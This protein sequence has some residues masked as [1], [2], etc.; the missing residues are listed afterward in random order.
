[1]ENGGNE[2]ATASR[3]TFFFYRSCFP[4]GGKGEAVC[5]GFLAFDIL[6]SKQEGGGFGGWAGD[7]PCSS[8]GVGEVH[9]KNGR[10]ECGTEALHRR[11]LFIFISFSLSSLL[12]CF[13]PAV[14]R[15]IIPNRC[16]RSC[17]FRLRVSHVG[18]TLSR[19]LRACARYPRLVEYS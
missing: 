7:S 18:A 4:T 17:C 5:F 3:G 2:F 15:Q 6:V 8:F 11:D 10:T 9:D 1:M 19:S 13:A 14:M 12:S 16:S